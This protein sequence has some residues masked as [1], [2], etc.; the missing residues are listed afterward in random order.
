MS[1]VVCCE[2]VGR[3]AQP[4]STCRSLAR[5]D[6]R[7]SIDRCSHAGTVYS[8]SYFASTPPVSTIRAAAHQ[9]GL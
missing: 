2:L 1:C 6:R 7:G 9:L 4:R 5:I 8:C 3:G